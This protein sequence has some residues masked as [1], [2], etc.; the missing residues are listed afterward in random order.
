MDFEMR[1]TA[2]TVCKKGE[3]IFSDYATRVEIVDEAAGEF[4]EVS[5]AGREGGGKIAVA[6][7][8]WPALRDAIDELIAACRD[9]E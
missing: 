2:V 8:E 3:P 9:Q 6:S 1:V 7:N 5:Q 4:V